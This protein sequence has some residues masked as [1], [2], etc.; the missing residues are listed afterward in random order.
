MAAVELAEE[1]SG[2][3]VHS[4]TQLGIPGLAKC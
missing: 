1:A 2:S 4:V 3:H